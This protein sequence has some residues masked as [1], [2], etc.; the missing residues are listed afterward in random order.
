MM[1][2]EKPKPYNVAEKKN[3]SSHP[4]KKIVDIA[5]VLLIH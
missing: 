4:I 3:S 1:I 2:W 5:I